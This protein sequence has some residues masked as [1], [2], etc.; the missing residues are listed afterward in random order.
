MQYVLS[1]ACGR[2]TGDWLQSAC[3]VTASSADEA[4]GMGVRI[5]SQ[6]WPDRLGYENRRVFVHP[7][8]EINPDKPIRF[9][10]RV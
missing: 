8:V 3:L 4:A 5:M 9:L 6:I 2:P 7:A 1:M 10:E